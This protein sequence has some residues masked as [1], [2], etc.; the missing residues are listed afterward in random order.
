MLRRSIPAKRAIPPAVTLATDGMAPVG[1]QGA[2]SRDECSFHG[3]Y[4][5]GSCQPDSGCGG[6]ERERRAATA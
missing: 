5:A 2:R 3:T 1:E 6:C 4:P